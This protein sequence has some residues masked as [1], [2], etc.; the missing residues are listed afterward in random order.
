MIRY[1]VS[2]IGWSN[3]DDPSLGG[4]IP[5]AQCLREASEIGFDG[6]E[7]GH[8]M[9]ADPRALRATLAPYGLDLVSGWHSLGLLG[10]SVEAEK[11]AMA[12]HLRLLRAMGCEVCI[13]SEAVNSIHGDPEAPLASRP[14]LSDDQ[15]PGFTAALTEIA[16]HVADAGL[17]AVYHHHMGTVIQTGE[18]LERLLSGT[19]EEMKLALDTGHALMAGMDPGAVARTYARRIG[20]LHLK[21]L[22]APVAREAFAK[23]WSFLDAVRA[24]VFTVPG[25][26]EGAVDF[27]PVLEAAASAGYDGWLVIEAEQDPNFRDPKTYQ[28][29]GLTALRKMAR[30]T[31]VDD[32]Q[33]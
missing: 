17:S 10:R 7:K 22:R 18:D 32:Q 16:R 29:M 19:G 8:K 33:G 14:M 1:G 9:P 26:E 13:L 15:W 23:G 31:G 5:L 30:E 4:H 25:D 6:I 12:P 24:G 21:N 20:H 11:A 3:D 2:P 27:R 28:A